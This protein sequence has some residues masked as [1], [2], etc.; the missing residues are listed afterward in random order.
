MQVASRVGAW[1]E[2]YQTDEALPPGVVAPR[3]GAWIETLPRMVIGW[4]CMSPLAWGR[5]S[6]QL[7]LYGRYRQGVSP[8]A[9]G[10]GSKR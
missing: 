4:E 9:W 6:K 5:G 8:L 7:H 2:T 3:V 1:I 10:R